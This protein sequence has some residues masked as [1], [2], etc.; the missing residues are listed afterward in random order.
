VTVDQAKKILALYRPDTADWQDPAFF[1]ARKIAAKDAELGRWFEEHC[2]SYL[3]MREKFQAVPVPQGLLEQILS[4]RPAQAAEEEKFLRVGFRWS[5]PLL[6]VAALALI[7]GVICW[8]FIAAERRDAAAY[9]AFQNRMITTAGHGYAMALTTNDLAAVKSFL[10]RRRAPSDY[11]VPAGLEKARVVGCA[12]LPYN[13]R[14]VSMICF[15]S[16]RPLQP[17]QVSDLWLFV[18]DRTA[19]KHAPE[20]NIPTFDQLDWATT[21]RWSED[22]QTYLLAAPGDKAFLRTYL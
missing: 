15:D 18:T 7:L 6:A 9:R 5:R 12:V 17:G 10:K 8:Q 19:V 1:K 4:E 22:G 14:A 11:V 16:G 20:S 21:A 2:A 13:G 3:A